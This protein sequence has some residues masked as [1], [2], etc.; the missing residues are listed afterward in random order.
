MTNIHD[1]PA[2]GTATISADHTTVI[3]TPFEDYSGTDSFVYCISDGHGGTDFATANVSV[4][5]VA[6]IPDLTYE[7]LPGATVNQV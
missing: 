7:V 6:D 2:H 3:Y 4:T 1:G 5:A